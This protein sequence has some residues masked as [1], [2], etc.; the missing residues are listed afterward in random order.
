MIVA[1]GEFQVVLAEIDHAPKGVNVGTGGC[2]PKHVLRTRPVEYFD[3][4]P[5]CLA[6]IGRGGHGKVS[7]LHEPG[8]DIFAAG[9][10]DRI[11]S[12]LRYRSTRPSN[13]F[14]IALSI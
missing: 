1:R 7:V 6:P 4:R 5:E 10:R 8:I 14:Y 2:Q 11:G 12:F 13:A 3:R 9:S